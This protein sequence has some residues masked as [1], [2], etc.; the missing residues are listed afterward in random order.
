M[1]KYSISIVHKKVV[2]ADWQGG[3]EGKGYPNDVYFLH[4]DNWHTRVQSQNPVPNP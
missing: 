4:V 3:G 2:S 1:F